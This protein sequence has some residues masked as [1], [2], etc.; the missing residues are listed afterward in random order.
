MVLVTGALFT[1]KVA[2]KYNSLN[3][4]VTFFG[5]PIKLRQFGVMHLHVTIILKVLVKSVGLWR[6]SKRKDQLKHAGC[7]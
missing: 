5:K 2:F 1:T 4:I 7:V 3:K 6:T